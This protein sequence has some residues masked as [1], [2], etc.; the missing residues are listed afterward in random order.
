MVPSEPAWRYGLTGTNT[1]WYGS[2][3]LY[4]QRKGE[5]W[6]VPIRQIASDL[7][8]LVQQREQVAA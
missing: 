7:R 4:R 1:P 6:E 5:K 3:Y 8:R 2:S